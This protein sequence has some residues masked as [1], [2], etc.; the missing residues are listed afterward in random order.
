MFCLIKGF[1]VNLIHGEYNEQKTII[2]YNV[3]INLFSSS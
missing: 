1:S 2:P 3:F